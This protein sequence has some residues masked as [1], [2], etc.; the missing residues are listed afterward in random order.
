MCPNILHNAPW[1]RGKPVKSSFHVEGMAHA[2][3]LGQHVATVVGVGSDFYAYILHNLKPISFK[4]YTLHG[5]VGYETHLLD[6]EQTENLSPDTIVTFVSLMT[7]MQ[8][9]I[10]SVKALFLKLI[11]LYLFHQADSAS[12]LVEI[13]DSTP[14]LFFYKFHSLM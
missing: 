8:I 4:P 12:L 6:S 2:L 14:A 1:Q 5:I 13:D 11:C 7:E 9:G 10:Y 3:L